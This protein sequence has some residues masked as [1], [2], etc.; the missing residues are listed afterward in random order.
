MRLLSFWVHAL[1]PDSHW[2][3]YPFPASPSAFVHHSLPLGLSKGYFTVRVSAQRRS[4]SKAEE[5]EHVPSLLFFTPTMKSSNS[6]GGGE[7]KDPSIIN[8]LNKQKIK[9]IL[10]MKKKHIK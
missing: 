8:F 6:E 1:L 2:R 10:K 4:E 7:K 9:L 5:S 3:S